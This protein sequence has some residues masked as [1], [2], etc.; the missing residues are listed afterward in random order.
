M[1]YG[2]KTVKNPTSGYVLITEK[3]KNL[4]FLTKISTPTSTINIAQTNNKI[5]LYYC[6]CT[7]TPVPFFTLSSPDGASGAI[8][9]V[10]NTTGNT[11]EI[12]LLWSISV[13]YLN[14]YSTPEIYVFCEARYITL[15]ANKFGLKIL[16]DDNVNH[17]FDSRAYPLTIFGVKTISHPSSPTTGPFYDLNGQYCGSGAN[18]AQNSM[19]PNQ[20]TSFTGINI[21]SLRKPLFLYYSV[22]QAQ[23]QASYTARTDSCGGI[24]GGGFCVGKRTITEY[25]STYWVYYRATISASFTSNTISSTW[26]GVISSCYDSANRSSTWFWVDSGGGSS[27]SGQWPYTNTTINQGMNTVIS[28]AEGATYDYAY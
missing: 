3:T 6:T 10:T 28:I 22:T 13:A 15:P 7:G 16:S 24:G 4:H 23:K 26:L 1:S 8:T 25:V 5:S 12:E 27:Q 9:R 19:A 14:S 20:S 21:S 17:T 18:A 11:W 2:I